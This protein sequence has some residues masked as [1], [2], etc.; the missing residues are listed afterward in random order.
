M[1]GYSSF[2]SYGKKE[3][4]NSKRSSGGLIC[5]FQNKYKDGI[6]KIDSSH[7]DLLWIKF[8]KE[9]FSLD[10]DIYF[11]LV[12][13]I[14]ENSTSLQRLTDSF[15]T[16]KEEVNIFSKLGN[17]ILG[18]DFNSRTGK[19]QDY[20]EQETSEYGNTD[21]EQDIDDIFTNR[22]LQDKTI[23]NLGKSLIALCLMYRLKI[24]NG[25]SLGDLTGKRLDCRI[26]GH[27]SNFKTRLPT[28]SL[29][30]YCYLG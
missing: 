28:A 26:Q 1:N 7:D 9:Y 8:K 18:G 4:K 15:E 21:P 12:Y 29:Y 25:H 6:T 30:R 22:F 5:Y 11:C 24:A 17:I 23:N 14:P 10:K 13:I 3:H 16:L 2:Q 20:I 19:V 27:L